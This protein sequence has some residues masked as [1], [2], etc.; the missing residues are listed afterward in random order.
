MMSGDDR[1]LAD[2][3]HW[4]EFV[5]DR[6][7]AAPAEG[8]QAEEFRDYRSDARPS[9]RE[10]YRLNH[11]HQTLEFVLRKKAEYLPLRKREMGIWE[12]MEFLNTL[13]DDSD[14]D[15]DLSQMEHLMQTAEAIR[16]DGHPRWFILTGL[17]HDLGKI[18]CLFGEP[19]WAVVGD[20]FPVGCAWSDRVVFPEFFELN[21]DGE[22]AAYQTPCGIYDEGCGLDRVHLSWGHDEYLYQVVKEHLPPEALAMIRYHSFYAAH[23]EG[24]YGHLMDASDRELFRWVRAFNPY[25]LYTKSHERPDVEALAPFYRELIAEYFPP[26]LRW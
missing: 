6:Y 26:M 10:F 8:K 18:L 2:L 14:P 1:P 22:V 4:E 17:I 9:V 25:D 13:V 20:T 24:A 7:A 3:E 23:R 12:A 19:Q 21:P 15:T 5:R 16:R 11:A